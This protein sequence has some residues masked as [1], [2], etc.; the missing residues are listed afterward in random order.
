[1]VSSEVSPQPP[2]R[3]TL[4]ALLIC[5]N[6]HCLKSSFE[7]FMSGGLP[8]PSHSE[9]SWLQ[10]ASLDLISQLL[11]DKRSPVTRKE[12]EKDLRY[13]FKVISG[14]DQPTPELVSEF[15]NLDRFAALSLVLKFK[16]YMLID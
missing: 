13:F 1:M 3:N 7:V 4:K 2:D 15:L 11:A 5:E 16:S 10:S 12:Y 8:V 6:A 14:K 9:N